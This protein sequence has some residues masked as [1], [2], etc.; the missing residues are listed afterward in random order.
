MF[1]NSN[2]SKDAA[3]LGVCGKTSSLRWD[4]DSLFEQYG[5]MAMRGGFEDQGSLF[6]YVDPED[7]IPLKHPLRKI[8]PVVREV[9]ASLNADFDAA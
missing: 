3:R 4:Y 6:S 7:R 9:L 2:I 1:I 8:R 5:G